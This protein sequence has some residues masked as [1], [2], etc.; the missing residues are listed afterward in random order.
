[1][2]YPTKEEFLEAFGKSDSLNSLAANL[3]VHYSTA[4]K[5][6]KMYG[7]DITVETWASKPKVKQPVGVYDAIAYENEIKKLKDT[8]R[9][10]QKKYS[11]A[12]DQIQEQG[13]FI[14][15]I[16]HA[17]R[18][19]RTL[20]EFKPAKPQDDE[21]PSRE[22]IL[23]ISDW[24]MGQLVRLEDTGNN[25]YNWTIFTERLQR[26]VD[27]VITSITNQ[28]KAYYIPRGVF[29]F[30]GDMVE[31]HDIFTGHP[32]QLDTNAVVQSLDG[33]QAWA[34]A[35]AAIVTAFP[36]I[37]WDVYCVMG[38]H[39]KPGGRKAGATP[40]TYSFD[41][42]FYRLLEKEIS[43]LEL[44][45]FG[46]EESGA[47]LFK[48][49]GYNCLLTHGDEFKG[50]SGFPWYG[51]S[52]ADNKHTQNLGVL[53]QY[54]FLGHWHRAALIPVGWGDRIVNGDAVGPNNLSRVLT[55]ATSAPQQNVVFMSEKYGLSE[56]VRIKLV[57]HNKLI[58]PKVYGE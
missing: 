26:W 14:D 15:S 27:A 1:L 53:Y 11:A 36:D 38:N 29:A 9:D 55:D 8:N 5:I 51:M 49:C 10:V 3:G 25:E 41:Y 48:S 35:M 30:G 24:Q 21:N 43:D 13:D 16:V 20:P 56:L 23:Q 17:S 2:E 33:A 37:K 57:P 18:S 7:V 19:P 31:G 32:W 39:G 46:I 54:W 34:A 40:S 6:A 12:L 42:L 28:R 45:D 58:Q 50:F 47:L 44:N 52:K 22:V 4:R